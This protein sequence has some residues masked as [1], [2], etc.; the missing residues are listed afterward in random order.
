MGIFR[1][2]PRPQRSSLLAVPPPPRIFTPA[3][4]RLSTIME[5][6]NSAYPTRHAAASRWSGGGWTLPRVSAESAPPPYAKGNWVTA[7]PVEGPVEGEKLHALRNNRHIARRGGWRKVL[8]LV[9]VALVIV[10]ALAVG[11]GVGLTRRHNSSPSS[12]DSSTPSAPSTSVVQSFPLGEYSLVTALGS[13]PT[14]CTSNPSTWRCYPYSTYDSADESSSMVAFNWVFTNTSSS[15]ASNSS[16][17]STGASGLAANISVSSTNNPFS[18]SF[19]NESLTYINNNSDPRYTFS[20][21]MSKNTVPTTALT[22]NNEATTCFFN[23]TEFVA[24]IYLSAST[25]S[26]TRDF[27]SAE[28]LASTGV[29]G[30]TPWPY[31]VQVQQVSGGGTDVPACYYTTNGNVGSRITGIFTAQAAD[32]ECACNYVNYGL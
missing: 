32:D 19:S 1:A 4:D 17:P 9:I 10:L 25:A 30:Y 28:L 22:T 21:T 2:G 14:N 31:A 24:T 11:L 3:G 12:S 16:T 27:P 23:Q 5:N 18:I 7:P 6:N 20:F 29:G 8:V 26:P 13:D 15:Y